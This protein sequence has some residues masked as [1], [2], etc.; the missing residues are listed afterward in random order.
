MRE[1]SRV[2][3]RV[4]G[5]TLM[6]VIIVLIITSIL[7]L[8]GSVLWANMEEL[9]R[10]SWRSSIASTEMSVVEESIERDLSGRRVTHI[11]PDTVYME[12]PNGWIAYSST[13]DQ[14]LR[15]SPDGVVGFSGSV[16]WRLLEG[17][18]FALAMIYQDKEVWIEHPNSKEFP[19]P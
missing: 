16:A 5:V 15:H 6:E 19:E 8:L 13:E 10:Y 7:V 2:P 1:G 11:R 4:S 14:T 17:D 18:I 9:F 12:G 3:S